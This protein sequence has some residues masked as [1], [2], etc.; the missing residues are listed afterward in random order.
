LDR[1]TICLKKC[2]ALACPWT[3]TYAK[4]APEL[5]G[6]FPTLAIAF[7]LFTGIRMMLDP[8]NAAGTLKSLASA[9]DISSRPSRTLRSQHISHALSYKLLFLQIAMI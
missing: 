2:K 7:F 1:K 4:L 6:L 8:A 5:P 9:A 3:S